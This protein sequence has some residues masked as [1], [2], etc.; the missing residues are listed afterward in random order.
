MTWGLWLYLPSEGRCATEIFIPLKEPSPRQSLNP[1]TSG[2]TAS[3]LTI[4]PRRR[5]IV[6]LFGD[7]LLLR[8]F[9]IYGTIFMMVAL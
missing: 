9:G 5:L 2:L 7:H 1:R 8:D 3:T 4:T 6:W